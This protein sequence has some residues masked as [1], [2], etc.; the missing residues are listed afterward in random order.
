MEKADS[1]SQQR[2]DRLEELLN[3]IDENIQELDFAASIDELQTNSPSE[4]KGRDIVLSPCFRLQLNASNTKAVLHYFPPSGEPPPALKASEIAALIVGAGVVYGLLEKNIQKACA[5]IRDNPQSEVEVA[6][7]A[8]RDFLPIL[9]P[10]IGYWIGDEAEASSNSAVFARKNDLLLLVHPANPGVPG[11]NVFGEEIL[12]PPAEAMEIRAGEN[13]VA[14]DQGEYY[15]AI[16]GFAIFENGVV[17]VRQADRDAVCTIRISDDEMEAYLSIEPASGQ[18]HML[19]YREVRALLVKEGICAGLDDDA[20]RTALFSAN[21]KE[22]PVK[23]VLIARGKLPLDGANGEILWHRRPDEIVER[24]SIKEDG[25][26][27]FYNLRDFVAVPEGIHLVTIVPPA[28]GR[29][30]YTVKGEK[31]ESAWGRKIEIRAGEN[32]VKKENDC[33]WFAGCAGRYFYENNLL[34][35]LPVLLVS[36][37]VDFST[38]HIDFIGD[39]IVN[40][41]V[42]D[43]FHVKASGNITVRGTVEAAYVEA[44]KCIEVKNGIFG[45]EKGKIVARCDVVSTF[46]QNANVEAGRDVIAGNQILNSI[47]HAGARVQVQTGKGIIIGGETLAGHCIYACVIG[48]EYGVR[49]L[50][51]AGMSF[52]VFKKITL[53][54][55][56]KKI[57]I[58]HRERLEH[59]FQA[60][61]PSPSLSAEEK[62][63]LEAAQKKRDQLSA[64]I[65]QLKDE[66]RELSRQLYPTNRP[67]IECVKTVMPDVIVKMRD[68][69]Y[70][71]KSPIHNC[72][73]SYDEENDKIQIASR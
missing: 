73:I 43:G 39:V 24:Y 59:F 1:S 9:P 27:D 18:G 26:I 44:G 21:E 6:I 14:N 33:E 37:D 55:D 25:S 31:L 8:G 38:G 19:S 34:D 32:I 46:L 47:V 48:G 71:I 61:K 66:L 72:L 45:K 13:V 60:N 56:K 41:N 7:A 35:V 53:L 49:T 50:V 62:K 65:N 22:Q 15:A 10:K 11:I 2:F 51:E 40:G 16:P 29:D 12:P 28:K 36:G 69:R 4:E 63:L 64:A 52:A 70:K 42:L 17:T 58:S 20:I 68:R 57:L 23:D 54:E 30:G 3:S 67:E 5:L